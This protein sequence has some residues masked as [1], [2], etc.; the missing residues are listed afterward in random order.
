MMVKERTKSMFD[1]IVLMSRIRARRY[2]LGLSVEALAKKC[3]INSCTLRNAEC[4]RNV[5]R[6][7]V[8]CYVADGLGVSID[9]LCGRTDAVYPVVERSNPND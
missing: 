6:A 8:L 2:E 5:P 1:K 9:W 7:D 4:G 3:D